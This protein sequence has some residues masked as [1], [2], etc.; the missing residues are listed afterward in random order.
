M[1]TQDIRA[2]QRHMQD[3]TAEAAGRLQAGAAAAAARRR[4]QEALRLAHMKA[5]ET[6]P[7]AEE[8]AVAQW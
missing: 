6:H 7:R 4:L 3:S 1:S 5:E 8:E 2:T